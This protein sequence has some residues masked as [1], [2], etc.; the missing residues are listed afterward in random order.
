MKNSLSI[1]RAVGYL[2]GLSFLILLL[3]AMP[4][5][6]WA[7]MPEAVKVTGMLHGVLF[8]A[9]VAALVLVSIAHR[10]SFL[11]ALGGF[12]AAFLPFGPF[13]FDARIRKK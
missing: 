6:Y 11:R 3:I 13:V 9:Y 7:G 5:K 10:W 4:L 1:F 12:A 8:V 2:E